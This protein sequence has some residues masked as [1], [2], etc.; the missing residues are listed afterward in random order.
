MR[1]MKTAEMKFM[2]RNEVK[3]NRSITVSGTTTKKNRWEIC[4]FHGGKYSSRGL[5]GCDAV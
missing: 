4:G 3:K 5:L 2:R 1:R